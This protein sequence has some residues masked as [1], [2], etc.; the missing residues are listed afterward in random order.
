MY[1]KIG[2]TF[3][4]HKSNVKE[5]YSLLDKD[6]VLAIN[7][8]S[9]CLPND[10][11]YDI[12]KFDKKNNKV[13]FIASPDWDTAREP[14]VGDSYVTDIFDVQFKTIKSKGQIYHHKWMFVSDDYNGFNIQESKAWSDIWTK[15]LPTTREIKSRIGYKK[16][17]D[18]L[19]KQYDLPID[20]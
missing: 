1:K 13:S 3:Y 5:L 6:I 15:S 11:N 17:W 9:D 18:D 12:L 14:L 10:F 7:S 19:L 20:I 8:A 2:L 16:Y 4:V